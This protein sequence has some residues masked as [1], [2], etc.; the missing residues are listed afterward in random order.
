LSTT[1]DAVARNVS[2]QR[3]RRDHDKVQHDFKGGRVQ[4]ALASRIRANAE[5]LR[6]LREDEVPRPPDPLRFTAPPGT[7]S[8]H[9]WVRAEGVS[10]P[11][12]LERVDLEVGGTGRLLITGPNGSGKSTLLDVLAGVL[13]PAT[14]T[15]HRR[16]RI[17]LLRQD[18]HDTGLDRSVVATYASGRPGSPDELV[19]QLLRTGLFEA[20]QLAIAV[21]KL[22]T[23]GRRRLDVARLLA[24]RHDVLLLDEPTN[25]LAPRLVEELEAAVDAFAGAVVVVS[26]DRRFRRTFRGDVLD[27]GNVPAES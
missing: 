3:E 10:V 15:V 27:L 26:H 25:H 8:T 14:G 18:P 13:E 5:K 19:H 21:R 24:D 9:G 1:G 4:E 20:E 12:R 23:G 16:G 17:G 11:G 22:S 2:H 7:G 6:R